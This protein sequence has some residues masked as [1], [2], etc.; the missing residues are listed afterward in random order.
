MSSIAIFFDRSQNK[1]YPVTERKGDEEEMAF[2][3]FNR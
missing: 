3:S 2:D 1:L